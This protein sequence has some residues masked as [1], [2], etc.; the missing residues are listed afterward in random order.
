MTEDEKYIADMKAA[1]VDIPDLPEKEAE[2]EPEKEKP[3]AEKKEE[4]KEEETEVDEEEEAEE[5]AAPGGKK[6][7]IYQE[8]KDKKK[9]AR[10][11]KERADALEKER[12]ELKAQVAAL[13]SAKTTEE[14]KEA[15][16]EFDEFA[17]KYEG[18]PAALKEMR[19]L[20]LK[21]VKPV[22]DDATKERLDNFE[23][24]QKDNQKAVDKANFE[25]EFASAEQALKRLF[26][27][28]KDSDMKGIKAELEK[29]AHT[30]GWNDKELEY[31]AFK[32]QDKLSKLISPKKKG[33]ETRENK[34]EETEVATDFDPAADLSTMTPA[35]RE[36]W[37]K[38][39]REGGARGQG[40]TKSKDGKL[41]I[42]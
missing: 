18:D 13:G 40:L 30:K 22:L 23:K 17:K 16:D 1:G 24:W 38:Q 27:T 31:I 21:G 8:Y 9:E 39:Y 36:K 12:D 20:F 10:T 3:A 32:H 42:I 26:P 5:P 4:E 34:G 29:L 15:L 37:E 28:A 19:D 33:M 25:N 35:Q 14:K 2:A 6:R 11:E 7:S 41:M